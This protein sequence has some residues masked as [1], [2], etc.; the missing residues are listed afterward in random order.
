MRFSG[1]SSIVNRFI[2]FNSGI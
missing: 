2:I 1:G